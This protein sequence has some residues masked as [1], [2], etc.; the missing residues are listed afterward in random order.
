MDVFLGIGL[1]SK[2]MEI[3]WFNE[4]GIYKAAA[5]LT[6]WAYTAKL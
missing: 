2:R 5:H 6:N 1:K 3:L 4:I